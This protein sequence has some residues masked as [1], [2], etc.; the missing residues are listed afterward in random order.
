MLIYDLLDKRI[1]V[2]IWQDDG[3]VYST[4]DYTKNADTSSG[5]YASITKK[6]CLKG[7]K[8]VKPLCLSGFEVHTPGC[9]G[10]VRVW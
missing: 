9:K 3:N 6:N 1:S 10:V 8:G 5:A 4:V 2:T 7:C